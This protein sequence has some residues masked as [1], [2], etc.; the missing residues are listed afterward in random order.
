YNKMRNLSSLLRHLS[1][2]RRG[3]VFPIRNIDRTAGQF[4][5]DLPQNARALSNLFESHQITIVTIARASDDH[6]EI[7]LIVI[8][9]RMF[10]AQIVFDSTSPQVWPRNRIRDR[11]LFRDHADVFCAIDKNLV[12]GQQPVAFIE[13]RAK[14]VEEFIKLGDKAFRKIADLSSYA[15]VGGGEP[16][17]CQKLKKVIEFFSLRERV[18][19]N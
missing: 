4:I 2:S 16:G 17:A 9:V 12:P 5:D 7:V 8:E 18:E 14:L 6:V 1:R 15:S 13:T 19:K 10:A 3:H 11:A